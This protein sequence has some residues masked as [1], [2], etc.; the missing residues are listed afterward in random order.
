L[1]LLKDSFDFHAFFFLNTINDN[2][3][4]EQLSYFISELKVRFDLYSLHSNGARMRAVS[5]AV[6]VIT[7][8][9]PLTTVINTEGSLSHFRLQ[10]TTFGPSHCATSMA[11]A[12]LR[13]VC[14]HLRVNSADFMV[15]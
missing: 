11:M 8:V 6:R 15:L 14:S 2:L 13:F 12:K 5:I 1:T 4:V 3:V 7:V 9:H 10:E